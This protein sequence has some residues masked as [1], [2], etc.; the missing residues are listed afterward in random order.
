MANFDKRLPDYTEEELQ[1]RLDNWD[2][3]FGALASF[4]LIRRV[5]VENSKSS[6]RFAGWSLFISIVA[7]AISI[8]IGSVQI[9][10]AKIQVNPILDEQVRNERRAYELCKE[11][12]NAN[13]IL[14]FGIDGMLPCPEVYK[15]L[16]NKF[17]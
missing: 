15:R 10:L 7:I 14:D 12:G 3:R 16:Q 17:E 5:M 8:F 2:P 13:V 6:K 4:E 9:Y 1:Q 11:P